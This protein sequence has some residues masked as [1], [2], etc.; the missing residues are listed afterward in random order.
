MFRREIKKMKELIIVGA[1]GF[2]RELLQWVK[3]VNK[4]DTK[5]KI[6]G[7]IDDNLAALDN[8]ECDYKIIGRIDDWQPSESE[9]FACGI[10]DPKDKEKAVNLLKTRGANFE[11]IVHPASNIGEFVQIGEGVIIYPKARLTVNIMIGDFVT[12]LSSGVGHDVIIGNYSTISSNCGINGK[13]KIGRRVFIGSNAVIVPSRKIDDDAF[14]GAGSVV[15]SNIKKGTKV[16]GN[17]AKKMQ[18]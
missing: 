1:G 3:D 10:A 13:V 6:K 11:Q 17:P 7:F 2:G 18:F 8:Y 4:I 14:V 16:M 5:W 9:T 12:L 15:V